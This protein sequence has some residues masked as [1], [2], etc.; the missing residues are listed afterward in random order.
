M[1]QGSW[2]GPVI[3]LILIDD[4]R[5]QVP[6]HKYV[7]DTTVSETVAKTE[8]N[9]LQTVIEELV[10]WSAA[11]HMNIN[12]TK[13][14]EMIIGSLRGQQTPLVIPGP[15]GRDAGVR[16]QA[17]WYHIQQLSEMVRPY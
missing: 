1:P 6:T 17:T 2:L 3:F 12:E 13:T 9:Q 16:L 5:L 10:S 15:A 11:N 4:L 8:T 7:D 14:K